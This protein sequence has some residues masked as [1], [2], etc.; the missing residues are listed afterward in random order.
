MQKKYSYETK[1]YNFSIVFVGYLM[2]PI[3]LVLIVLFLINPTQYLYL[4][5]IGIAIYG[6]L[7]TFVFKSNPRDIVID[8]ETISFVSY[9]EAKYD[10]KKLK[11]FNVRE[12]AN[13]QFYIRVEEQGGKRG[14]YWVQYYYFDNREELINELYFIEKKIHPNIIKFRGRENM[15]NARPCNEVKVDE[16]VIDPFFQS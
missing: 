4:F 7:N 6:A 16:T 12:F 13:A 2:I 9:G 5:G 8:D 3:A 11:S 10:I 1:R 14:R 15:F